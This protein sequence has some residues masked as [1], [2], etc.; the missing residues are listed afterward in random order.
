MQYPSHPAPK[1]P[2]NLPSISPEELRE[3]A[4][5]ID[6]LDLFQPDASCTPHLGRAA[7]V[8]PRVC[9]P[10]VSIC[11][12]RASPCSNDLLRGLLPMT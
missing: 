12:S 9:K 11:M 10:C 1:H 7:A 4:T 3:M 6:I 5:L 2:M 8:A